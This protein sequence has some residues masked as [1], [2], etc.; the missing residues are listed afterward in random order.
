MASPGLF[1]FTF[2]FIGEMSRNVICPKFFNMRKYFVVEG[3]HAGTAKAISDAQSKFII[4]LFYSVSMFTPH[5]SGAFYISLHKKRIS[6]ALVMRF[7]RFFTGGAGLQKLYCLTA[8]WVSIWGN[9]C[10][11]SLLLIIC[12][13]GHSFFSSPFEEDEILQ[14][15]KTIGIIPPL[16][17]LLCKSY[18]LHLS[19]LLENM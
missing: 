4:M 10:I 7:P 13:Q 14:T 9:Y 12:S 17:C 11:P 16:L 1:V 18:S 2:L 5:F 15:C 19:K 8:V 6:P 3:I